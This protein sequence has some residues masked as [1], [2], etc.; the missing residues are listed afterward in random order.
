MAVWYR[1]AMSGL[2]LMALGMLL[3]WAGSARAQSFSFGAAGD[4]AA[5]LSTAATF[6]AV[7][8]ASL[9]FFLS[10]GD[11]GYGQKWPESN[12]QLAPET[13]WCD[14]VKH[15]DRLGRAYP[16]Q[17][18]VGNHEDDWSHTC[19]PYQGHILNY[20]RCLPERSELRLIDAGVYGAQYVFDYPRDRPLARFLML[21]AGLKF[22]GHRY[23]YREQDRDYKWVA[24]QMLDAR[25]RGIQWIIVGMHQ[26][27][28]TMGNKRCR[29]APSRQAGCSVDEPPV[30]LSPLYDLLL[31]K[32]NGLKAD[33]ILAGD[34]HHYQRSHQLALSHACPG[35]RHHDTHDFRS[36][37][38]HTSPRHEYTKGQGA[39][40]VVAGTGGRRLRRLRRRDKD[41]PFF[42]AWGD[43]T[44]GFLR[45]EVSRQQLLGQF[46]RSA[47][48]PFADAF[49]IM[50]PGSPVEA[51]DLPETT[52]NRQ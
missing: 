44:W 1:L 23:D 3:T 43:D 15:P 7:R 5:N 6:A 34:D 4:H 17:L 35:V 27:C 14:G 33:L 49:K 10:L 32:Q 46:V 41:R 8:H 42:A 25:D 51:D 38:A 12:R 48:D 30:D 40:V 28:M 19:R 45:V 29:H 20:V 26:P 13:A 31:G 47:G 22:N 52:G 24:N 36:C 2:G 21:G 18:I 11:L 16:I 50:D 9:D 39:I 37:I